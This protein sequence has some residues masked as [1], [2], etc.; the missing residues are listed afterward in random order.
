MTYSKGIIYPC[1]T[2]WF[3]D[4]AGIVASG[5]VRIKHLWYRRSTGYIKPDGYRGG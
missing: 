4:L 3:K 5:R 1:I 2:V